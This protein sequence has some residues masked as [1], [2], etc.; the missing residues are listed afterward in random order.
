MLTTIVHPIK[1]TAYYDQVKDRIAGGGAWSESND[2]DLTVR[3][4]RSRRFY[5][6]AQHWLSAQSRLGR[7]T[8]LRRSKTRIKSVLSRLAMYA[9]RF[10]VENG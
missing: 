4:R 5:R 6:F 8:L 3:G 7:G 9:T 1:G 2:R 10:E